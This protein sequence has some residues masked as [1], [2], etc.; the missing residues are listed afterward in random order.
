MSTVLGKRKAPEDIDRH[1]D[2]LPRSGHDFGDV[3]ITGGN[4]VLGDYHHREER[5][6]AKPAQPED[7][8]KSLSESLLFERADARVHDIQKPLRDTCSWLFQHKHWRQ[9]K[10]AGSGQQ[11]G[12]LWIKGHAGCGKSTIMKTTLDELR[13][14]S[15]RE[16]PRPTVLHYFFNAR[17]PTSL[18]KSS[19]GLYRWLAYQMLEANPL[20]K[21]MFLDKFKFK[22]ADSAIDP[23]T[24]GE[25]QEF[26]ADAIASAVPMFL[27]ILIDALDEGEKFQEV[28]DLVE[29][30]VDLAEAAA[31]PDSECRLR[32]C[33]SSRHFPYLD[34]KKGLSL[35]VEDQAE[36]SKDI[37]TYIDKKLHVSNSSGGLEIVAQTYA[38]SNG[39]FL[40]VVLVI[41]ILNA[42]QD[43]GESVEE[44]STRLSVI[45]AD[46]NQLFADI[47]AGKQEG[48]EIDMHERC[49]LFLWALY[50]SRPLTPTELYVGTK[51]G[52][53]LGVSGQNPSSG[54][55]ILDSE[56]IRKYILN[57]SC[58]LV[59]ATSGKNR[60]RPWET[61]QE[62]QFIHET[63]R[64]FLLGQD[65]IMR[66][67]PSL[68]ANF[69]G[70][71]HEWLKQVCDSYISA[72][73]YEIHLDSS[74]D[75]QIDKPSQLFEKFPFI[76]CAMEHIYFHSSQ[77]LVN[78]VCQQSFLANGDHPSGRWFAYEYPLRRM[79]HKSWQLQDCHP[80][81]TLLYFLVDGGYTQLVQEL[82]KI[83]GNI[84]T[85]AGEHGNVLAASVRK[86]DVDLTKIL[87]DAGCDVNI[88]YGHATHRNLD[89]GRYATALQVATWY[90]KKSIVQLLLAHGADINLVAGHH[91]TAL[92]VATWHG[93]KSMI[94]FLLDHRADINIVGGGYGTA[95]Q[96]AS[97]QGGVEFPQFLLDHGADPNLV[98]G[99]Y[100]TALQAATYTGNI[101]TVRLLLSHGASVDLI[102][103]QFGT[104][105]QAAAYR[106]EI[107]LVRLLL[108]Y[109]ASVNVIGG[110]YGTA[111]Q[112][113]IVRGDEELARVL[114]DHGANVDTIGGAKY[115]ALHAAS[116]SGSKTLAY[117]GGWVAIHKVCRN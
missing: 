27:Y 104:A 95:L 23:W 55:A 25:L 16:S 114:L 40:W 101:A 28:R 20:L 46:L 36:Q 49:L 85:L 38:K 4:V 99:E 91:G 103:G 34:V 41:K 80:E 68:Q 82:V 89:N 54:S 45:P 29:F 50:S 94:Q 26:I 112:A 110:Q 35:V 108:S 69:A 19:L 117:T 17:G 66:M 61:P 96:A 92:H 105:L 83:T 63:V 18:E 57:T 48:Q 75:R 22:N 13:R 15:M 116:F 31:E 14:E 64:E 67:T 8:Y 71:S 52:A 65:G 42:A 102:G 10:K 62:V 32:I 53:R 72:M 21:P 86:G 98:G 93:A 6:E 73:Y 12:F 59:H 3:Y 87:L 111:L 7:R 109:G 76:I 51:F 1:V 97:C 60:Q 30:L 88:C 56:R 90:G 81:T 37:S 78:G 47:L 2:N 84:N 58:G 106:G 115:S 5:S 100:G 113:A 44:L 79:F 43:R 70:Q 39:I 24:S 9:W 77:A 33:L 107:C 11:N 74:S